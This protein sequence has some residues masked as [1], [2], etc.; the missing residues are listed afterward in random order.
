LAPPKGLAF[1]H[2]S[3]PVGEALAIW[4]EDLS[5]RVFDGSGYEARMRRLLERHYGPV[6][7]KG[8][9]APRPLKE[10]LSAYFCGDLKSLDVIR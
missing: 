1:D 8:A 5:L 2:I 3:T 6:E 4:D 7:P 10:A 9:T